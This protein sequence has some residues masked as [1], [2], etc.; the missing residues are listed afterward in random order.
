M[1]KG[2]NGI[3]MMVCLFVAV[4][5]LAGCSG[6]KVASRRRS[7]EI[8]TNGSDDEWPGTPQ[9]YDKEKH[10]AIKIMNDDDSIYICFA[11]YDRELKKK[12]MTSGLTVWIDPEGGKERKYGV[13]LSMKPR[14]RPKK[15]SGENQGR[16]TKED[17]E[18]MKKE[19]RER[20]SKEGPPPFKAPEKLEV[21]HP[22]AD[23]PFSMTME[24]AR[25]AGVEIGVGQPNGRL[26]YEYRIRTEGENFV[27]SLD[28]GAHVG[29]G[30]ESGILDRGKMMGKDGPGGGGGGHGKKGGGMGGPG[31]GGMS[32]PPGGGRGGPGNGRSDSKKMGDPFEVWLKV[33][34][35]REGGEGA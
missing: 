4:S 25:H 19:F 14:R 5:L 15:F 26:V 8:E 7:V 30:I 29:I 1:K 16:M 31:R 10:V 21:V 13:R 20:M 22:F 9:Y 23:G 2:L 11:A 18:R 32:G 35:A 3:S 34:W 33:E 24:E 12:L 27:L 17:R 6:A 28:T